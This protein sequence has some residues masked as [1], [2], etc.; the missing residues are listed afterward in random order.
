MALYLTS[1]STDFRFGYSIEGLEWSLILRSLSLFYL[2]EFLPIAILLLL[3]HPG[4]RREPFFVASIATL[5]LLPWFRYG[6][7]NDLVMRSSLPA[8]FLLCCYCADVLARHRV[9]LTRGSSTRR[10]ALVGLAVVLCVGSVTAFVELA[11]AT[12]N[13]GFLRY[14][15]EK[16]RSILTHSPVQDQR[17]SI[18]RN[19]SDVLRWLLRAP[20]GSIQT[21]EKGELLARAHF[22]VYRHQNH[23]I[24][25]KT[26]CSE[27]DKAP[28]RIALTPVNRTGL[29]LGKHRISGKHRIYSIRDACGGI[30]KLPEYDL[31]ALRIRQRFRNAGSWEVQIAFDADGDVSRVVKKSEK[32]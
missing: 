19:P 16:N 5:L 7:N 1:G 4:L 27:E 26:V 31:A 20:D 22:D 32:D 11:R 15:A 14:A 8:L 10:L 17:E 28:F 21:G 24:Y 13:D 9:N 12:K 23:L 29:L 6:L 2:I 18:G 25:V 30:L 3:L